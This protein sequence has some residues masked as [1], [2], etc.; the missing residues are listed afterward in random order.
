MTTNHLIGVVDEFLQLL[1]TNS[2]TLTAA[3]LNV[4]NIGSDLNSKKSDLIAKNDSQ[5]NLKTQLKNQ[6]AAT[7]AATTTL[8]ATFSSRL[9]A[10]CGV[11]GKTTN[12]GK[13]VAQLRSNLRRKINR[14]DGNVTPLPAS[15]PKSAAA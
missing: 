15:A 2:S 1:T 3:G 4:T 5:S 11:V 9:D 10:V 6:T 8:Y 14:T 12:F 13:Q 7:D